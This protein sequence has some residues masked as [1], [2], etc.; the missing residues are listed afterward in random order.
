VLF[1]GERGGAV[2]LGEGKNPLA[3][4]A[5]MTA[6]RDG[7]PTLAV[8]V[9]A[10]SVAV[11]AG[12]LSLAHFNFPA[13]DARSNQVWYLL[14]T[15]P[16]GGAERSL[17]LLGWRKAKNYADL[18][19]F[20]HLAGLLQLPGAVSFAYMAD[21]GQLVVPLPR[22]PRRGPRARPE[23]RAGHARLSDRRGRVRRRGAAAR[24]GRPCHS[25]GRPRRARRGEHLFA[26]GSGQ[27]GG[28][29]GSW[30]RARNLIFHSTKLTP[31]D[32]PMKIAHFWWRCFEAYLVLFV[33][34]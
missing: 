33:K 28:G 23:R 10:P 30:P 22:A 11:P 20:S 24:P 15:I 19:E 9:A 25:R 3:T 4:A 31:L 21:D 27:G 34:I 14:S 13:A 12:T 16:L 26:D 2:S 5:T 7:A 1:R 18:P 29:S 6:L 32:R 17:D 8:T